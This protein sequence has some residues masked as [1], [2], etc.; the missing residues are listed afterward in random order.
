MQKQIHVVGA[1]IVKDGK[2]LCAQRGAGGSLAGMWEFPGGKIEPSESPRRALKREIDEE[3]R[4]EIE[5]AAEVT[6]TTYEYDFATIVLTTFYCTLLGGTPKLTE[7]SALK[8]LPP[9]KLHALEWAPADVP[10]VELISTQLV[11]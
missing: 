5:V 1:V 9:E 2:V 8:W 10:A 6:T 3:L 11:S 7:H 4:C